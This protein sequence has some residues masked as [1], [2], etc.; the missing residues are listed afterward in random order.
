MSVA[1]RIRKRKK[2]N[3]TRFLVRSM[4]AENKFINSEDHHFRCFKV[5]EWNGD[6]TYYIR[7]YLNGRPTHRMMRD[8]DL[9]G[10]IYR[11]DGWVTF[12]SPKALND[13][14]RM[15]NFSTILWR[16]YR[17]AEANIRI[18]KPRGGWV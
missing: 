14:V 1:S 8:K 11:L 5:L 15:I 2:R 18:A 13:K 12:I 17:D 4:E 6:I 16:A 7:E 3:A 10:L 9:G